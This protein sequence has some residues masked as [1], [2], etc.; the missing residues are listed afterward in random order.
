MTTR[1]PYSPIFANGSHISLGLGLCVTT[2][3]PPSWNDSPAVR[4]RAA[5]VPSPEILV[6]R[7]PTVV[8]SRNRGMWNRRHPPIT[9]DVPPRPNLAKLT[10]SY[11]PNRHRGDQGPRPPNHDT[12][13]VRTRPRRNQLPPPPP[14]SKI[15][16][17]RR[18]FRDSTSPFDRGTWQIMEPITST[19][20]ITPNH[21]TTTTWRI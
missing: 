18:P 14:C 19:V 11:R 16:P 6:D 10:A 20:K 8:V 9:T 15:W 12:R 5:R 4:S 7:S 17:C 3:P 1:H 21:E 13:G 2:P